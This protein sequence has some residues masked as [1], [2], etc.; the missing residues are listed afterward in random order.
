[1]EGK[2]QVLSCIQPTGN[3]HLGRYFGAIQNWVALQEK[4]D[5]IYG[6][7][8]YHGMTTPFDPQKLRTLTWDVAFRLMA[9]G[10]DVN[11]IFIHSLVPEH[12]ELA[13]ILSC[14]TSYGELTRMTQF[15]DKSLQ[16]SE[17]NKDA[18]ISTGL[19]TY[20]VLQAA[21]IIIYHARYVPVGKDQE[22]HLELTRNIATRFNHVV[23]KEYFPLP[24]PL[25]TEIPKV[26]S[27][28]DPTRKMS[29]SLGEKHNIDVF[30]D[31]NRIRKQ[32]MSAVTDSGDVSYPD[33]SPGVEN[34]FS[35]LK[36]SGYTETY[37]DLMH[38][39]Q[40]GTLG[41]GKLKEEVANAI[42][43]MT[44]P[45]RQKLLILNADKRAVK[46]QIKQSSAKIRER[47]QKTL[48]EVRELSG[49]I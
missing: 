10:L 44:E 3:V 8:N 18:F 6:V 49:L 13:W 33:M 45:F 32:I 15:K 28:A 11:N 17:S 19:F 36:A 12:T 43:E 34:L 40:S 48:K 24:E 47:A 26:M 30:A 35:L 21:D 38:L 9:C 4:Y 1:M 41:Y 20:P 23:K 29:A 27:T 2:E 7:V 14:M 5:C 39:Y 37:A 42:I 25:Y 16:I 22:Q 46:E 31:P